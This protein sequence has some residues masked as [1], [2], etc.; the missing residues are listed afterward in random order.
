MNRS[1][2]AVGIFLALIWVAVS[3]I[4]FGLPVTVCNIIKTVT[5]GTF[6]NAINTLH[7][8]F[9]YEI[10]N[11]NMPT[12]IFLVLFTMAF[13]I[14]LAV[15]V[16]I[17]KIP[18]NVTSLGIIIIFSIL[19]RL[20]L[21]PSVAI[22]E[23]DFY[24]YLWDGKS[25]KNG[26]NPFKYAPA[27][28]NSAKAETNPEIKRLKELRD[29]NPLYFERINHSGVPT[30]YP[31]VA[32]VVFAASSIVKE[33]SILALKSIFVFFDILAL[34][35]IVLL[36]SH[37]KLN[38]SLAVIYGWSPLVLKEITNSGHY[39]SITIFLVLLSLYCIVKNK[40]LAG[41][42]SLACA[43]LTK[44]Y[45]VVLLFL[46]IK[47]IK[48]R[49]LLT[50]AIGAIGLYVPFFIWGHTGARKVFAGLG[51]YYEKWAYNGSLFVIVQ[52]VLT[53]LHLRIISDLFLAKFITGLAFI[54]WLSLS[55]TFK[56]SDEPLDL[57]KKTLFVL[58]A[59]FLL[60]PVGEPW[61]FCWAIPFL[62][63]FPYRSFLLLSWLLIFSYLSFAYDCGVMRTGSLEIPILNVIQY[64]PFF[65]FFAWEFILRKRNALE[66][67]TK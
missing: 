54:I 19:F 35:L 17:E 31:P 39:D 49:H 48:I 51:I 37:F 12:A 43:S 15:V 65:L 34:A 67:V 10:P 21:L 58:V 20:I 28:V 42:I 33:D 4:S 62:C 57:M 53:M 13:F 6:S 29:K 18:A 23:N 26:I 22:H 60:N 9:H 55:F 38:P 32:Q 2:I 47:R 50:F 44:F 63:F 3:L 1:L 52:S 56:K 40:A 46:Y 66:Y 59:L 41:S 36:L 61:Y 27:E 25:F 5:F 24:R 14:Y 64:A 16:K 7:N 30:I 8:G 11:K 45:P